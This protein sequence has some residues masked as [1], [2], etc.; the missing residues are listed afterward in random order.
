MRIVLV[1]AVLIAQTSSPI[2]RFETDGFWL[3]LHHYL[4]VLGRAEAKIADSKRDAVAA[5]PGDS[6]EGLTS[7]SAGEQ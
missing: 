6:A 5:A 2:F 7:L 1:T 4:Y 3:N